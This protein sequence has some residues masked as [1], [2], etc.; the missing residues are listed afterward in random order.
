MVV[1]EAMIV[2]GIGCRKD[3]TADQIVAAVRAALGQ[4]GLAIIDLGLLVTGEIKRH[5][6]GI[7][8]AAKRFGVPL[9]IL[10]E[11]RLR[12]AVPLCLTA[13]AASQAIAGV[14]SLSEAAAIAGAG[15]GGRLLGPRLA[16]EG[17]T[18]A[19]GA[20]RWSTRAEADPTQ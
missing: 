6:A 1:G 18:C 19:L 11:G 14:P 2:A 9:L 13:S 10:D 16:S 20:T 3:A 4:H 17:V 8:E 7:A 5:E 15:T 12:A